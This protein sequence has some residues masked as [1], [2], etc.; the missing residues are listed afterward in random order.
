MRSVQVACFLLAV[1]GAQPAA[2]QESC[3]WRDPGKPPRLFVE[4]GIVFF[5]MY[6]RP[7]WASCVTADGG[8]RVEIEWL[9][10]NDTTPV[11][12]DREIVRGSK[13]EDLRK[14]DLRLAPNHVCGEKRGTRSP[15]KV[16]TTGLPGE[17]QVS[18]LL[19]VR[20]RVK[21]TGALAP[22][23]YTSQPVDVPCGLCTSGDRGSWSI[24]RE[25]GDVVL[26][27]AA[28]RAWFEC[29]RGGATLALR[30][31]TGESREAVSNAIAP[32]LQLTGLEKEFAP[33]DGKHVLR[34]TV[35]TARLCA[36]NARFWSFELWG[37]G[38]LMHLGGGGRAIHEAKC[39]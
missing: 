19:P 33:K 7:D 6:Y 36:K 8:K 9:A 32:E 38:E 39:K 28:E 4:D 13:S 11:Q 37:R 35:P 21:A 23:A 17:E 16:V 30:V 3:P 25:Q 27:M 31:F 10:G 22:L 15:G 2:A 1:A 26:D 18:E 29:A 5:R 34:K 12:T 14:L 24:R 20:V